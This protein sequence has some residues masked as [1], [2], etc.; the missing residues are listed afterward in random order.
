M[1]AVFYGSVLSELGRLGSCPVRTLGF[2]PFMRCTLL[3]HLFVC[4]LPHRLFELTPRFLQSLW[5]CTTRL[6]GAAR[7]TRDGSVVAAGPERT[8]TRGSAIRFL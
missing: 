6:R 4:Q 1:F 5:D 7:W 2:G 3:C 8:L